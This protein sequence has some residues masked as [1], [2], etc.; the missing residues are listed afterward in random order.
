MAG[1]RV[2]ETAAIIEKTDGVYL[3]LTPGSSGWKKEKHAMVTTDLLGQTKV[4]GL[5]YEN[6]D[7]SPF[8]IDSDYTGNKRKE[9]NVAPG[10]F[11]EVKEGT[12]LIKI[13]P[14]K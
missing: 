1:N 9:K 6:P 7:G 13:W 12:Q 4:S 10:P 5:P 3:E 2:I 14:K 8:P 11:T